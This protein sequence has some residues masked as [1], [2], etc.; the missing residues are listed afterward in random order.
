M[1][2][3][4]PDRQFGEEKGREEYSLLRLL[5]SVAYSVVGKKTPAAMMISGVTVDSRNVQ[6]GSLFV[7]L[8]GTKTDGHVYLEQVKACAAVV[9]ER[10]RVRPE[11]F[12]TCDQCVIVVEDSHLAYAQI[13]ANLY[14]QPAQGLTLVGV[15]GTNG[16]TTVSYLLESVLR[17]LG[18]AVGVIGTVNY[19]YHDAKG[20]DVELPAPFTTPEPLLLQSLLKQMVDRG[21]THVVMEV[22]SHALV[23][24]RLGDLQFDVVAFTNLSRDHLDY[25][26]DMDDYFAAKS[27]LFR[28]HLKRGGK[29]VIT[30]TAAHDPGEEKRVRHLLD[31]CAAQGAQ[32]LQCGGGKKND[33]YPLS[34]RS[35][36][37]STTMRL[38]I[39]ADEVTI[40]S[41]LVGDFN[42]ANL[43]TVMGIGLALEVK[44]SALSSALGQASGAPGRLQRLMPAG[45][46]AYFRPAVFVD[47]AHTPDALEKVLA[48]LSRL[49]HRRLLCVFGCGGDR[50][51]GK[52]ALMGEIAGLS[53][54]VVVITDDNPRTESPRAIVA[55]IVSGVRSSGL[56]ERSSF[57]LT[58]SATDEKGYLVLHSRAAAIATAIAAATIEDI[59]LIAGKGHEQ[60]QL[61]Q[62]GRRFFDDTL[63]AKRALTSWRLDSLKQALGAELPGELGSGAG[64]GA[65]V[66]DSRKVAAG[67]IFVALAG[68]R[69]DGHDFLPQVAAAGA[70]CLVVSR[71]T[72]RELLPVLPCLL[73]DDTLRAL[74]DLAAYRRQVMKAVSCPLVVG[75]TGSCGKTTVKEM[76]AAIF[77]QHCLGRD[78]GVMAPP[79]RVLKTR[80]NFNNLIGLPLS[81][82]PI[83]PGHKAIILEMGMNRPG[84]IA[85]LTEIADPDIACIVNVHAVHLEGLHSIEGV[86][87]AKEE[88]FAGCAETTTLVVNLD[89]PRVRACAEKYQQRKVFYAATEEGL[90]YAQATD[91][92]VSRAPGNGPVEGRIPQVWASAVTKEGDDSQSFILHIAEEATAVILHIPGVHNI[93]DAVAAAAIAHAAGLGISE[94]AAGLDTFRPADKRMQIVKGKGGLSILNDTYN[95]NPASMRAALTTFCQQEGKKRMAVLG[96]MLELGPASAEAH[97]EVGSYAA[98]LGLDYLALFGGFAAE[99]AMGAR[100]AG[101]DSLRV[102]I[103]QEKSGIVDWIEELLAGSQLQTG[104]WLL[105]KGSRGMRLET[106]V[107]QLVT[108][109]T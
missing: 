29:G 109:S 49:P 68:E 59:V 67:D 58:T 25:H 43:Q 71:E 7:A 44:G 85:R 8:A 103:F 52:R 22:S 19:R 12:E 97:R 20:Q 42:M 90:R 62:D 15:T 30:R 18:L 88:L 76:T 26:Q 79:E 13:A 39:P 45:Q 66:T 38:H 50:D 57:W 80:G 10:G 99:T 3:T 92:S 4:R 64:F 70:G 89:D 65:V 37:N 60:Y 84:E 41:P 96:D 23:Q 100:T 86:A 51:K 1:A 93:S 47:Y 2:Q 87:R 101:M 34:V 31:L 36:L 74:G 11:Q 75:I 54:D 16:K 98:G 55:E 32:A 35:G 6:A 105:V 61:G 91:G 102:R 56:E 63:E 81:L 17:Q 73:V 69:F 14:G 107:E 95:A 33:I 83:D 78:V 94:I 46:E 106:V 5:D 108:V 48:T 27:L 28:D 53:C 9:V 104:D 77:E 24:H 72:A 82:L 40:T 21:V